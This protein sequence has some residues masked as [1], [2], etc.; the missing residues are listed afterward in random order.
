MNELR[1]TPTRFTDHDAED[2]VA[3]SRLL[4]GLSAEAEQFGHA[5][6]EETDDDVKAGL[7]RLYA[8]VM[9]EITIVSMATVSAT[10]GGGIGDIVD[11]LPA[12]QLLVE[13][14]KSVEPV[15][16][17]SVM[18][19]ARDPETWN[20]VGLLVAQSAGVGA[21][22]SSLIASFLNQAGDEWTEKKAGELFDG[23]AEMA[24]ISFDDNNRLLSVAEEL[25]FSDS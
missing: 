19:R 9:T 20:K 6:S 7:R 2:P 22:R 15:A 18:G 3:I 16:H 24:L 25:P 12:G 8:E 5:M 14:F 1:R 13:G 21:H 4:K 10:T 17:G 23:L 11:N